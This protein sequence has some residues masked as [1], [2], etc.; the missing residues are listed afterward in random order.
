MTPYCPKRTP[1]WE[2]RLPVNSSPAMRDSHLSPG[3]CEYVVTNTLGMNITES[4]DS[5]CIRH[6]YFQFLFIY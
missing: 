2:S 6:E 5:R 3:S 1:A 4:Q